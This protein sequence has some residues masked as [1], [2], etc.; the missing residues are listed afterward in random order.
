MPDNSSVHVEAIAVLQEMRAALLRYQNETHEAITK[1]QREIT[2]ALDG[3]Q[4]RL[5]HW[6]R[7]LRV[8][9]E[10]LGQAKDALAKCESIRGPRGERANCSGPAAA[11]RQ[12]ERRVQEAQEAIRTAQMHIKR[13]EE[14]NARFQQQSHR[15][16]T[17]LTSNEL[18]KASALLSKYISILQSYI[19]Q[20]APSVGISQQAPSS[21]HSVSSIL[22]TV[23]NEVLAIGIS[24]IIATTGWATSDNVPAETHV[25][26][27]PTIIRLIQDAKVG[28]LT[29]AAYDAMDQKKE[30]WEDIEKSLQ[31]GLHDA[32]PPEKL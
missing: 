9:Q 11:V 23:G 26:S 22:K 30:N 17:M 24:A 3:L 1:A 4:E 19:A 15:F 28:D 18:P 25:S 29:H 5:H 6:Q 14:A 16:N 2:A 13:V 21:G 20:Q 32:R 10:A 31:K 12:A 8:R 7:Q 27:E